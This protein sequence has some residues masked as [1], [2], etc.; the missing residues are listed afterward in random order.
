MVEMT[1][2]RVGE[3]R[4]D[5]S[6]RDATPE[7]YASFARLFEELNAPEPVPN[8]RVYAEHV[9]PRGF[10]GMEAESPNAILCWRPE[11]D[12]FHVSILAVLP[13]NRRRG[14]GRQLMLEAARRG[15]ALGFTRWQ[16]NV[17][18]GNSAARSLY[19]R[20]G[21]TVAFEVVLFEFDAAIVTQL[22]PAIGSGSMRA[23]IAGRFG[24]P[25]PPVAI[26]GAPVRVAVEGDDALV[27]ELVAHGVAIRRMWRMVGPLP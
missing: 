20:L 14:L 27:N 12:V 8:A 17:L 16:L 24:E 26:D 19:E 23:R 13:E 1:V 9:V 4:A 2:A 6:I 5:A 25:P 10:F 21:M 22:L 18:V 7:D 3:A 15:R 11:G